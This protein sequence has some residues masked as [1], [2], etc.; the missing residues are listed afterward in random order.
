M[1]DRREGEDQSLAE[2][3][4]AEMVAAISAPKELDHKL[5]VYK[6]E[7]GNL[8]GLPDEWKSRLD[9]LASSQPPPTWHT[10]AGGKLHPRRGAAQRPSI[11]ERIEG[12]FQSKPKD[13]FTVGAP[14]NVQHAV[15]VTPD[16]DSAIGLSGL[17]RAW[18]AAL[19]TS[20]ITKEEAI[21]HPKEVMNALQYA[22]QGPPPKLPSRQSVEL[23][24]SVA[25][26]MIHDD[27]AT[28]YGSFRRIGQGASGTV[29][30]AVH[31]ATGETRALKY[32]SLGELEQI[33]DEVAMQSTNRHPNIVALYETFITREEI[34]ISMEFMDGGMLTDCCSVIESAPEPHIAYVSRNVLQGLAFI[35]KHWRIHRDI[36][37]DNILVGFDGSVKIAD[38]G[39]AVNLT[40]EK[41][42][43]QSVVGTPYWMA[44]ELI[45]GEAYDAKVDIWSYG[46]TML[47]LADGEPPLMSE[48]V[49]RALLM[50]TLQPPPVLR[51]PSRWSRA[52]NHFIARCLSKDLALRSRAEDLLLHPLMQGCST[53]QEFA[54]FVRHKVRK[55]PA[56]V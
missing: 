9:E 32:C 10:G 48:P 46:I 55:Q 44:P 41:D 26:Q 5:H 15:H 45:R 14:F 6:D 23:A 54:D 3:A 27:P 13:T 8:T 49:M 20:G 22:M 7:K 36:K 29:Y 53:Q 51:N 24:K 37:S 35:H 4:G 21:E 34:C 2:E 11:I 50:I 17:P 12:L 31:T 28:L 39:F 38:F 19:A 16:P 52:L 43:R 1:S 40:V 30:S 56:L 47:E 25:A 18:A 42:R 33:K